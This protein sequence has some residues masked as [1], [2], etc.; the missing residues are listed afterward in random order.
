MRKPLRVKFTD[1]PAWFETGGYFSDQEGGF[2]YW[3]LITNKGDAENGKST[4][5]LSL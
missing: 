4:A 5:G 1:S 3:R 2:G